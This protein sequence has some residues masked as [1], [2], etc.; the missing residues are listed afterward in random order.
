MSQSL[1]AMILNGWL[2]AAFILFI[3][4]LW[5]TFRPAARVE[6]ERNARIPFEGEGGQS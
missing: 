5:R 1:I 2:V 6:M 4:I 3:V